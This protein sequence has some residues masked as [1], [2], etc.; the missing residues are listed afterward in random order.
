LPI[1]DL[2]RED[3]FYR[4]NAFPIQIP[5]LRQRPE[6]IP[7]LLDFFIRKK[8]RQLGFAIPELSP[9]NIQELCSYS[10]PGNIRELQNAVERAF[11]LWGGNSAEPFS[12]SVDPLG[13]SLSTVRGTIMAP[14]PQPQFVSA[15]EEFD[16]LDEMLKKHILAALR[17]TQGRISGPGGA[18]ELLQLPAN[19]LRSKMKKLGIDDFPLRI[20]RGDRLEEV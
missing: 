20:K 8:A 1:Q 16:T 11:I 4:L 17:R 13:V 3:L 2:F 7:L 10:W 18:A 15:S 6:D 12:V 5:P 14:R 19:T 9:R